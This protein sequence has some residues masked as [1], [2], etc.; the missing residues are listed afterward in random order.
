MKRTA[1]QEDEDERTVDGDCNAVSIVGA[2]RRRLNALATQP[3]MQESQLAR[4]P[5]AADQ[6]SFSTAL[7]MSALLPE[8]GRPG[9]P[10]APPAL[11]VSTETPPPCEP[12]MGS[13]F[14][15]PLEHR[16]WDQMP[17]HKVELMSQ[18]IARRALNMTRLAQEHYDS[19]QEI[20]RYAVSSAHVRAMLVEAYGGMQTCRVPLCAGAASLRGGFALA[21][22]M[23]PRQY[24]HFLRTGQPPPPKQRSGMCYLCMLNVAC[25][26]ANICLA[27]PR[28]NVTLVMPMGWIRQAPGGYTDAAMH[29]SA[30]VDGSSG[31]TDNLRGWNAD[32]YV[33]ETRTVL[34]PRRV[35]ADVSMGDE[36]EW[37]TTEVRAYSERA[38]LIYNA[39]PCP[40]PQNALCSAMA[41]AYAPLPACEDLLFAALVDQAKMMRSVTTDSL[42]EQQRRL[43]PPWALSLRT[44]LGGAAL[45][46]Q[47]LS[48]C[49]PAAS[50]QERVWSLC[51]CDLAVARAR[52]VHMCVEHGY[53]MKAARDTIG[54]H[55]ASMRHLGVLDQPYAVEA[56]YPFHRHTLLYLT[57]LRA[58]ELNRLL[59]YDHAD[60]EAAPR[61]LGT[62]TPAAIAHFTSQVTRPDVLRRMSKYYVALQPLVEFFHRCV[63]DKRAC[64]DLVLFERCDPNGDGLLPYLRLRPMPPPNYFEAQDLHACVPTRYAVHT[65]KPHDAIAQLVEAMNG[66]AA[67]LVTNKGAPPVRGRITPYPLPLFCEFDLTRAAFDAGAEMPPP[68]ASAWFPLSLSSLGAEAAPEDMSSR[69]AYLGELCARVYAPRSAESVPMSVWR[70]LLARVHAAQTLLRELLARVAWLDDRLAEIRTNPTVWLLENWEEQLAA[71]ITD[72]FAGAQDRRGAV[73]LWRDLAPAVLDCQGSVEPCALQYYAHQRELVAGAQ[74]VKQF[75]CGHLKLAA[76]LLDAR[77]ITDLAA[78][79]VLRSTRYAPFAEGTHCDEMLVRTTRQQEDVDFLYDNPNSTQS[80]YHRV[81]AHVVPASAHIM[82]FIT[83]LQHAIAA[84]PE[85]ARFAE[86]ALAATV[87]GSYPHARVVA[88]F[89]HW[90]EMH[91]FLRAPRAD[92]QR[93]LDAHFEA[94][95]S[96][97][98]GRT[99]SSERAFF[100]AL[101]EA[102][103]R[104]LR[105]AAAMRLHVLCVYPVAAFETSIRGQCDRVRSALGH[106]DQLS[107]EEASHYSMLGATSALQTWHAFHRAPVHAH[108]FLADCFKEVDLSVIV[109]EC[110]RLGRA[111][112]VEHFRPPVTVVEGVAAYVSTIPTYRR[113]RAHWLTDIGVSEPAAMLIAHLADEQRGGCVTLAA[114]QDTVRQLL[115]DGF[116]PYDYQLCSL[117]CHTLALHWRNRVIPMDRATAQRQWAM[118]HAR[119]ELVTSQSARVCTVSSLH[120]CNSK[121]TY[122]VG[123]RGPGAAGALP[124]RFNL[125]S[126]EHTCVGPKNSAY[127]ASRSADKRAACDQVVQLAIQ[128]H[129]YYEQIA[130]ESPAAR[131]TLAATLATT[132]DEMYARVRTHAQTMVAKTQYKTECNR[133]RV[134]YYPALGYAFEQRTAQNQYH[135]CTVC[136]LCGSMAEFST[137]AVGPN[138]FACEQCTTQLRQEYERLKQEL[139]VLC[140]KPMQECSDRAKQSGVNKLSGQRATVRSVMD[141][142]SVRGMAFVRRCSV[143]SVCNERWLISAHNHMT[144]SQ[145]RHCVRNPDD[146][147]RQAVNVTLGPQLQMFR[148]ELLRCRRNLHR[149]V[150]ALGAASD[151]P[152]TVTRRAA[153]GSLKFTLQMH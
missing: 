66:V 145:I 27:T 95:R 98:R 38:E 5:L 16:P 43:E 4:I 59:N 23:S 143:C 93:V 130:D 61:P 129:Q 103:V 111:L 107:L 104:T 132:G 46:P 149:P 109:A 85:F 94:A 106:T 87:C 123:S 122:T 147:E 57:L 84:S 29:T 73:W 39:A 70:A 9:Q 118:I 35:P 47:E 42:C 44:A 72:V 50:L 33:L 10:V 99:D 80:L 133:S 127:T 128:R 8:F 97:G 37:E 19:P 41:V 12:E 141:D 131:A 11:V 6:P 17:G 92:R 51:F 20:D 45:M 75:L 88:Q 144:L 74:H 115:L 26:A 18:Y 139:C 60:P 120:C 25:T 15:A 81:M 146:F 152:K 142:V 48:V 79:R 21:Q 90:L 52:L 13:V 78:D 140:D 36:A 14:R 68:S 102:L 82:E 153:V 105:L 49:S 54:L 83:W 148:D 114:G 28:D 56:A 91:R 7:P 58:N 113:L 67:L 117:M 63:A 116:E 65:R 101:R 134:F 100:L 3:G 125:I 108:A 150:P 53:N 151:I 40:A 112:P 32:D 119:P 137:R 86:Q 138:G 136:P 110:I 121:R 34:T 76:A 96:A 69:D 31:L 89:E 64:D 24:E 55:A 71:R 2:V 124:T 30:D 22:Y 1:D 135:S 77:T 62:T 126:G